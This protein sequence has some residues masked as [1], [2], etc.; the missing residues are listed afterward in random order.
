MTKEERDATAEQLRRD[1]NLAAPHD[2]G[3]L[4]HDLLDATYDFAA[5]CDRLEA[6][7]ASLQNNLRTAAQHVRAHHELTSENAAL[8]KQIDGLAQRVAD[9]A[10][11][12]ARRAEK[13]P[14][15]FN[16]EG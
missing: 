2:C 13:G 8:R 11:L 9:Q 4:H 15:T 3:L 10:E 1:V 12:L 14:P 16:V 6:A 5:E 7:N